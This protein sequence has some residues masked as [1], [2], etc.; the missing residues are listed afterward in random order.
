MTLFH[1]YGVKKI[2]GVKYGL[3]GLN[4][5]SGLKLINLTPEF[6]N[7]ITS[8][9]GSILSTSRGPQDVD[10]MVDYLVRLNINILF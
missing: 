7:D 9:G 2:L 4:P 10:V 3:M 1:R 8:I 5:A 6:V